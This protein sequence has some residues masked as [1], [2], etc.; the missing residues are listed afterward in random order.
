MRQAGYGPEAAA[1]GL[2]LADPLSDEP[3]VN[4]T[5]TQALAD[6]R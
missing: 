6:G 3:R 2:A 1:L 5:A 4:L